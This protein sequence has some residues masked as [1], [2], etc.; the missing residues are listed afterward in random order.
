MD[1]IL[2]IAF[3]MLALAKKNLQRD[4]KITPVAF[5]IPPNGQ[6]AVVM[7][8]WENDDEK[9]RVFYKV[10]LTAKNLSADFVITIADS[11]S[12]KIDVTKTLDEI[13][14]E[15]ENPK[16]YPVNMRQELIVLTIIDLKKEKTFLNITEYSKTPYNFKDNKELV[17]NKGLISNLIIKGYKNNP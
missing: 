2:E 9:Y 14:I 3:G 4:G 5:V 8:C 13:D 7:L 1:E 6:T 15:L 17:A 10:G 12:R 16:F 11:Y